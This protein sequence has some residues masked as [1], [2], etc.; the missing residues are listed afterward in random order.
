MATYLAIQ[1][2]IKVLFYS[3]CLKWTKSLKGIPFFFIFKQKSLLDIKADLKKIP[4][5]LIRNSF[6]I[7]PS[8]STRT[9]G[10]Y[11]FRIY[12]EPYLVLNAKVLYM[13]L[14]PNVRP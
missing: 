4:L 5:L 2:Y 8:H 12:T 14:G 7:Q 1:H 10:Y 3:T 13:P 11:P 6:L 9:R